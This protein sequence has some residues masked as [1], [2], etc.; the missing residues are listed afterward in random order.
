MIFLRSALFFRSF[1]FISAAMSFLWLPVMLG[2]SRGAGWVG[3]NWS[4]LVFWGLRVICGTRFE[5]RGQCPP[6]GVLLA[7]KHMSMWDTCAI[8]TL[9]DD[10]AIVLK[11]GLQF[12]P[13]YGWY[14]WKARMIAI[15]SAGKSSTLPA[16]AA[17]A[18][19]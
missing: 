19:T 4:L 2:P 8:Y 6:N 11:R 15:D 9:L 16:T 14:L 7:V 3:R 10:P 17:S 5:V 13:L 18:D 12:I 1:A